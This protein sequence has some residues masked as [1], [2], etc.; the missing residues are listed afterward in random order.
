VAG[1]LALLKTG[2]RL[3]VDLKA[4]RVDLLVDEAELAA[5][6]AELAAGG[7]YQYPASQTPWQEIQRSLVG[8][9]DRGAILEVP[10]RRPDAWSSPRQSLKR[11]AGVLR[12]PAQP[13]PTAMLHAPFAAPPTRITREGR[14][15]RIEPLEAERHAED[16][17]GVLD[18]QERVWDYLP[19][20]PFRDFESFEEWLEAREKLPDPLSFAVIDHSNGRARGILTLMEI[21]PA[22]GVIEIG[23][24]VFSPAMQRTSLAT[25]AFFL[26]AEYVFDELGYRRLEWKCNAVNEA[27]KRAAQRFGFTPEG[28]F[29]KHMIVKGRNRD[30]AWFSMLD[31]E[32]PARQ[33][34]FRAWLSPDNFDAD[35]RQI[36][37]LRTLT[38][39]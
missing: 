24:I 1:G 26:A 10:A 25:E 27:S 15:A 7:G 9:L 12:A 13:R 20:G 3:R 37:P 23:H 33:S 29:R 32:W 34:G 8:Q 19:Y 17:W 38:A 2:D 14:F 4:S 35:G 11:S 16:L 39:A 28:V 31:D 22:A 21:R 36:R 6:Q 18:G 5:R 30:T